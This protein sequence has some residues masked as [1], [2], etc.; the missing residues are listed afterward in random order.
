MKQKDNHI[1]NRVQSNFFNGFTHLH[2]QA[3]R[4]KNINIITAPDNAM[5][6][7]YNCISFI[8]LIL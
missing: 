6:H 3:E 7:I 1:K 4:N 5:I 8:F 2:T